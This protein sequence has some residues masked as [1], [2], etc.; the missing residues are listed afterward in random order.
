MARSQPDETEAAPPV[1]TYK[2]KPIMGRKIV[3]A[4]LSDRLTEVAEIEPRDV[5]AD[6]AVFV[7]GKLVKKGENYV[8][9][10]DGDGKAIGYEFV[11]NFEAVAGTFI[12]EDLVGPV[13]H[14]MAERVA[15][16]RE[17][18]KTGQLTLPDPEGVLDQRVDDAKN[19]VREIRLGVRD[20]EGAGEK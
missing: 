16:Q 14:A 2:R 6:K 10:R 8:I 11:Q 7:V 13:V 1:E 4:K 17:F 15:H 19:K 3:E 20:D 18:K 9:V 12:D 5:P